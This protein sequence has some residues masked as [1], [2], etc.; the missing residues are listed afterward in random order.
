M[1]PESRYILE[2]RLAY[3]RGSASPGMRISTK[4]LAIALALGALDST[5][6][7]FPQGA[8]GR[9]HSGVQTGGFAGH[10]GHSGF[11]GRGH[12]R[13]APAEAAT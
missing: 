4:I 2:L 5:S 6:E 7:A 9:G 12:N 3:P 13:H 10:S 11:H 1:S 8:R